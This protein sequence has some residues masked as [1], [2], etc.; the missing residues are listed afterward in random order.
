M[1]GKRVILLRNG[2]GKIQCLYEKQT[3]L[4]A[5]FTLFTKIN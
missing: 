1:N 2:A 5:D 4:E 3:N